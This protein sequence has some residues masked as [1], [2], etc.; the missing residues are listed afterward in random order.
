[1]ARARPTR[2]LALVAVLLA[3]VLALCTGDRAYV[4][5]GVYGFGSARSQELL[6]ASLRGGKAGSGAEGPRRDGPVTVLELEA[7]GEAAGADADLAIALHSLSAAEAAPTAPPSDLCV[8]FATEMAVR[9]NEAAVLLDLQNAFSSVLAAEDKRPMILVVDVPASATAGAVAKAKAALGELASEAWSLLLNKASYR[10]DEVTSEVDLRVVSSAELAKD[11][12][13]I[14]SIV[15]SI[16]AGA[17]SGPGA[18]GPSSRSL[19][20]LFPAVKAQSQSQSSKAGSAVGLE[21]CMDAVR[22]AL[23]AA[24]EAAQEST[25][26]L[27]RPE[28]AATF[29][30]FVDN[31]VAASTAQFHKAVGLGDPEA[32]SGAGVV[33]VDRGLVR[34]GEEEIRRQ[35]L[36]MLLPFYKRQVLLARSEVA[37][38][39][40]AAVGEDLAVTIN[41]MDDLHAEKHK[42]L[43][44]FAQK[45]AALRPKQAAASSNTW[46]SA[47]DEQ[48]LRDSLE[49][50]VSGREAQAKVLGVLPRGRKPVDVSFHYLATH[51]FGRDYRQ[52]ALLNSGAA[53]RGNGDKVVYDEQL[54]ALA[55][56]EGDGSVGALKA[57]SMLRQK[58]KRLEAAGGACALFEARR[59][60]RDS[61]FA[62]EMLMLPLSIKNP[63]VP[64]MA[65]R[66]KKR[67]SVAAAKLD[68]NRV[69]LGPERF[70]RWDATEGMAEAKKGIDAVLSGGVS[71]GEGEGEGE[72]EGEGEG[73]GEVGGGGPGGFIAAAMKRVPGLYQHPV[74]NYGKRMAPSK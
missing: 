35:I 17:G 25:A 13:L 45:C 42:A 7:E 57:R 72:D 53:G 43:S 41:L 48:Q 23:I 2:A 12:A 15:R 44:S 18:V 64:L 21:V 55:D 22:A 73:E 62:R 33:E 16:G 40:N 11:P 29:P 3:G 49:E 47:F 66:A 31:L 27:Q 68:P 60:K 50:Y 46:N 10:S 52:D 63:S 59:V 39:F 61:E 34:R 14:N 28:S 6:F 4:K 30:V 51:P 67:S 9:L 37:K 1:M 26:K 58:A 70:I 8:V 19:D 36:A 69:L 71:V 65:G 54:A 32:G 20:G 24:Q 5:C 38:A 56:S 74:L